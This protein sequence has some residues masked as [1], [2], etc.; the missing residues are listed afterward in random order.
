MNGRMWRRIG[1]LLA[2]LVVCPMAR[3]ADSTAV[4]VGQRAP[5]LRADST[6]VQVG[7]RAPALTLKDRQGKAFSLDTPRTLPLVL[8]FSDQAREWGRSIRSLLD[9]GAQFTAYTVGRPREGAGPRGGEGRQG[10]PGGRP[11]GKEEGPPPGGGPPGDRGGRVQVLMDS[12]GAVT[13]RWIGASATQPVVVVISPDN[14]VRAVITGP[15]SDTNIQQLRQRV[16][17]LRPSAK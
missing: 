1:V 9:E 11:Q 14:V 10:P 8:V 2:G 4:Q 12:T 15:A 7:Q 6:A 13:Q 16:A 5:A 3:A 17:A